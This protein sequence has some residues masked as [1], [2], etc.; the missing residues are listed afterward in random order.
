MFFDFGTEHFVTG[1]IFTSKAGRRK[2]RVCFLGQN[3]C[4][5]GYGVATLQAPRLAMDE[6]ARPLSEAEKHV[7]PIHDMGIPEALI[8]SRPVANSPRAGT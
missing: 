8:G 4:N 6:P 3:I 7:G 5:L 2:M 1:I